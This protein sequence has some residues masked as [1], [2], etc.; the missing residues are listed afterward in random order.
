MG[1]CFQAVYG[2]GILVQPVL[3]Q[4]AAG[5]QPDITGIQGV[6][7]AFQQ[8]AEILVQGKAGGQGCGGDFGH[9]AQA[10]LLTYLLGA[11]PRQQPIRPGG[12]AAVA[13]SRADVVALTLAL[14]PQRQGRLV[15][16]SRRH[17]A[18]LRQPPN[19]RRG[20]FA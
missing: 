15:E 3:R 4:Q 7:H 6:H 11:S 19:V 20:P 13:G 9:I 16:P 5:P 17:A 12:C 10:Q 2:R 8:F 18:G 1:K 14:R